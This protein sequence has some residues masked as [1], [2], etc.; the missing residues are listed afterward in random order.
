MTMSTEI[1]KWSGENLSHQLLQERQSPDGRK[2]CRQCRV[3]EQQH[4]RAYVDLPEAPLWDVEELKRRSFH[5]A[6]VVKFFEHPP[7]EDHSREKDLSTYGNMNAWL[8]QL[9]HEKTIVDPSVPDKK[10]NY[11]WETTQSQNAYMPPPYADSYTVQQREPRVTLKAQSFM[12]G[13]NLPSSS[14]NLN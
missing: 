13:A 2:Y 12:D 8:R 6:I 11:I 14:N 10:N 5:R 3:A 4:A 9:L 1:R 7:N